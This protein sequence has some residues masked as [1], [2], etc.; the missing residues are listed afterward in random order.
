MC[1]SSAFCTWSWHLILV[2]SQVFLSFR[3]LIKFDEALRH[4][5]ILQ[6]SCFNHLFPIR[7]IWSS[8]WFNLCYKSACQC[9]SSLEQ[10]LHPNL[11]KNLYCNSIQDYRKILCQKCMNRIL[12]TLNFRIMHL[13]IMFKLIIPITLCALEVDKILLYLLFTCTL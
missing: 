8:L 6:V 3:P 5:I 2:H 13:C 12:I 11:Q 4:T 7:P 1:L 9:L 10:W